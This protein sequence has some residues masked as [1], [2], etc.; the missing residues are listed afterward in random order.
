MSVKYLFRM[1]DISWDMNY[2]NF[3]RMRDLFF[4]YDIRPIIGVIPNNE[5]KHLKSQVGAVS[6]SEDQF[7]EEM[8]I[9]Q[10]EHGWAVALHGYNHVYVTNDSGIFHLRKA[11]EFAGLPFDEQEKKIREGKRILEQNGLTVDA[12][13]A[14][15]HSLDWTTVEA[16]KINGITTITDGKGIYPY[17]QRG[18]LFVPVTYVYPMPYRGICGVHTAVF[19]TNTLDSSHFDRVERFLKTY[20]GFDTIQN[21]V[22]WAEEKENARWAIM[23]VLARGIQ[24]GEKRTIQVL[25]T[26]K[27][28][29]NNKREA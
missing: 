15:S 11:S 3:A 12:F 16:L 29:L 26:A 22:Q 2:E 28:A 7:W 23:N 8:R 6:I 25:Y 21:V 1:D 19:H 5:D 13:M 27:H 9:L 24:A 14:P 18:A 10:R 20:T 17:T 4:Q